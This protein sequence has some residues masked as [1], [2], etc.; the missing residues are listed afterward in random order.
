MLIGVVGAKTL[1]ANEVGVTPSVDANMQRTHEDRG[2][3]DEVVGKES[4]N[5][6]L[7]ESRLQGER[8]EGG[9]G[10]G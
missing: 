3:S 4:R 5:N 9:K 7:R 8:T 10:E 1:W 6:K 2:R